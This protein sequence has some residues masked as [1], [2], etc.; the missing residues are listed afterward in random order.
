MSEHPSSAVRTCQSGVRVGDDH[1]P[2]ARQM[3]LKLVDGRLVFTPKPEDGCYESQVWRALQD[4]PTGSTSGAK[5]NGEA[6][7]VER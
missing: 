4:S 2:I 6:E 7:R 5:P 3:V 1:T